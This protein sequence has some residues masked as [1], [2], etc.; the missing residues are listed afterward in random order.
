MMQRLRKRSLLT[1]VLAYAV[2]GMLAFALAAGVGAMGALMLRGNLNL[3][4][5][6]EPQPLDAQKSAAGPQQ[7]DVA[8]QKGAAEQKDTAEQKNAAEQEDAA[9]QPERQEAAQQE[10][11]EYINKVGDIQG[12]AVEI[13]LDSH[14]KLLRYDVLTNDDLQELRANEAALRE[15][16]DQVVNLDPPQGYE[17]QYEVF[18]SAIDELHAAAQLAYELVADPTAATKLTFDEYDRRVAE[19]NRGLQ[20]SNERLGQ[21]YETV[22]G[23]QEISPL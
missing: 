7:K 2:A 14:N 11:A 8:E 21:D 16:A 5:R 18:R 3:P 13:S 6:E 22:G 23:V 9:P 10:K 20:E 17:G 19:A 1:R 4:G 12:K 15:F